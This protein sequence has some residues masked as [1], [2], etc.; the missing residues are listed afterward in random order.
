MN[1]CGRQRLA[2]GLEA[3]LALQHPD[4]L[5]TCLCGAG[6]SVAALA[7]RNFEE[8]EGLLADSFR[9]ANIGFTTRCLGVHQ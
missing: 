1:C 6:P 8:I 3:A 5:G 9:A 2:P 7:T 4:L